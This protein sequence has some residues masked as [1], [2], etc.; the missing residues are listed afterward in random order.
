MI[1]LDLYKAID[2]M[3]RIS[4]AGGTF[5]IKF[6]KWNAA[7]CSGGDLCQ[8]ANAR[9]RPRASDDVV[10]NSS[11]KLFLT[12]TDTGKP[13]NCWQP[14]ITEFNGMKTRLN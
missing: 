5:R 3:R 9:L 8:I 14:L 6:R 1:T 4:A 7:T 13:L 11:Y 12:D 2:E 10:S